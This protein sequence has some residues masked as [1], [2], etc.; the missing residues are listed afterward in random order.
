V[1]AAGART[2]AA[3]LAAAT[4]AAG[5]LTYVFLAVPARDLAA[6][7]EQ[8]AAFA[9]VWSVSLVV[10]FG[11]MAPVEAELARTL[12]TPDGRSARRARLLA[13]AAAA[14]ALAVVALAVVGAVRGPLAE[15]LGGTAPVRAVAA[16]VVAS[17]LQFWVRGALLG[18]GRT[19]AFAGSVALD[20]ATRV[21][22]AAAV[23]VWATAPTAA[24]YAGVLVVSVLVSHGLLL[25]VVLRAARAGGPAGAADEP[26]A[27]SGAGRSFARA[28]PPLLLVTLCAQV[29]LNA[30]PV[31]VRLLGEDG[32]ADAAR[33]LLAFTLARAPLFVA[34]PLQ[35]VLV[36][37]VARMAREGRTDELRRALVRLSAL[38]L[39]GGL[40]AAAGAAWL[41]PSVLRLFAGAALG[42]VDRGDLALMVLG[43]AAFLGLL[44]VAAASVATGRHA[45]AAQAWVVALV[46]AVAVVAV[47]PDL[48]LRV[49]LGLLAG[50]AAGWALAMVRLVHGTSG[51]GHPAAATPEEQ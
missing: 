16:L 24:V 13:G 46:V 45:A 40:L 41:G 49:E 20:A 36:P 31:V 27:T 19:T 25:P 50:A 6:D 48:F 44:V 32:S 38:V 28:L 43:S 37:P 26:P 39:G 15:L 3:A 23:A 7:A 4:V 35:G 11:V 22:L 21:V 33:F 9:V 1:A 34:V 17:A 30:G 42:G 14:A 12:G 51:P 10:G 18:L 47:V 2:A 8:A 29:L 5:L